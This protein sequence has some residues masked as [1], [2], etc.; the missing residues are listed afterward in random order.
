MH[1][2]DFLSAY[3]HIIILKSNKVSIKFEVFCCGMGLY[4]T[5]NTLITSY[6]LLYK[7]F[8]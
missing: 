2:R 3:K 6:V 4:I 7:N 5:Y 1:I 8:I